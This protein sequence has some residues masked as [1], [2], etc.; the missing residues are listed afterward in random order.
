VRVSSFLS[1]NPLVSFTLGILVLLLGVDIGKLLQQGIDETLAAAK[2]SDLSLVTVF[3]MGVASLNLFAAYNVTGLLPLFFAL[4]F[5]LCVLA[6][7]SGVVLVLI[8]PLF[9]CAQAPTPLPSPLF[10]C[11]LDSLPNSWQC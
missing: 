7:F 3:L 5:T 1:L 10:P 9:L 8:F 6:A 4:F 2:S 11:L